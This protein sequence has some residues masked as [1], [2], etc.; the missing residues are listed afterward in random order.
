MR[1]GHRLD[2]CAS[3]SPN[4]RSMPASTVHK[5]SA[6]VTAPITSTISDRLQPNRERR[7][8]SSPSSNSD[9]PE[10]PKP[11]A[12]VAF[13]ETCP[14][15]IAVHSRSPHH[16]SASTSNATAHI[17]TATTRAN[18]TNLRTTCASW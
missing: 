15:P 10:S 8:A 9:A 1:P 5:Y 11:I 14:G 13:I 2:G 12:A 4:S 16:Q 6:S 7:A 17:S 3:G 18:S